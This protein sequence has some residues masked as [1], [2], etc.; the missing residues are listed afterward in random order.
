M[1]STRRKQHLHGEPKIEQKVHHGPKNA[2]QKTFL[3]LQFNGTIDICT[4]QCCC[5]GL[6][7]QERGGQRQGLEV[8]GQGGQ[9]QGLEARGQ[10]GQRQGQ[11]LEV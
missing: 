6:E 10:G 8:Q 5:Q 1:I 4:S 2:K 7:A 11:G 9:R 3:T